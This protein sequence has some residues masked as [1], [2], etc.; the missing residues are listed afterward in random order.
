MDL[1][2]NLWLIL[3]LAM[4]IPLWLSF[5]FLY[6]F[7][8]NVVNYPDSIKEFIKR[9]FAGITG[10]LTVYIAIQ[11]QPIFSSD[12][13]IMDTLIPRLLNTIMIVFLVFLIFSS[14]YIMIDRISNK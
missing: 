3:F 11:L 5:L 2:T 7:R 6:L 12:V 10:G 13:N 4:A 9:V 1:V 14:L 8:R